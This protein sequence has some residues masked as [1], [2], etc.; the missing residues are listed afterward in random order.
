[1]NKEEFK[2]KYL[3]EIHI[4]KAWGDFVTNEIINKL[5]EKYDDS[6]YHEI[7]KIPPVPRVKKVD[8]LIQK[9]FVTKAGKYKDPYNEITDKVGTR[10][11]VLLSSQLEE[12]KNIVENSEYWEA[13]F[14]RDFKKEKDEEPYVFGYQ[15]YHYVVKSIL[16]VPYAD[17]QIPK[18][19]PCEVQLRT[20]LQHAYAEM[21]HDTIYKTNI[22]REPEVHRI[23]AKSMALMETT[24]D[25]LVQAKEQ[26]DEA[27]KYIY[28]WEKVLLQ[29]YSDNITVE[30][31]HIN[32][33]DLIT[34]FIDTFNELVL[35]HNTDELRTFISENS[36][37]FDKIKKRKDTYEIF[38]IPIVL[39]VYFLAN[40][41]K[42]KLPNLWPIDLK[43]LEDIY[44]DL[45]ITPTW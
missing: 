28:D 43:P 26:I 16:K 36:F 5:K 25:L 10:F 32:L 17:Q 35:L 13:S 19:I 15:S 39:L 34:F 6:I 3:S 12:L 18:G 23:I 20:L 24:D 2:E 45:G 1:M 7:I 41:H 4:Y 42:N 30:V 8:S 11:V 21:T 14:D 27:S 29:L 31:I 40:K 37:I 9:A 44:S 38:N 33:R 22:R